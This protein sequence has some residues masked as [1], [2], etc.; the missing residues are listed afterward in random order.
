MSKKVQDAKI[1]TKNSRASLAPRVAH[2]REL[3]S[4]V[5]VGWRDGKWRVRVYLGSG[6][7]KQKPLGLADDNL[8]ADGH[9]VL[10][11][12][13]AQRAAAQAASEILADQHAVATGAVV[14]VRAACEALAL[15]RDDR[16]RSWRGRSHTNSTARNI[17]AKHVFP[18]RIA[19]VALHQLTIADLRS[20]LRDLPRD[21]RSS[22]IKR[23]LNDLRAALNAATNPKGERILDAATIKEGLSLDAAKRP[24]NAKDEDAAPIS[25]LS[26]EDIRRIV[27]SAEA[28]G[29]DVHRMLS[30]L[31]A[32]GCRF[33]QVLRCRVRDLNLTSCELTIPNS[34]KG[35]AKA[36][37]EVRALPAFVVALLRPAVEGR[38]GDAPLFTIRRAERDEFAQWSR[39]GEPAPWDAYDLRSPWRAACIAA[40]VDPDVHT[41]NAL[42]HTSI[43]RQILDRVPTMVVAKRHNT[44][45]QMLESVYAKEIAK[46]ADARETAFEI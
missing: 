35:K 8:P 29:A 39:T 32:T 14:T 28:Q 3:E 5:H 15:V 12:R 42:R 9:G 23:M 30:V 43:Q 11:Y 34:R 36:G 25:F 44:S 20:W 27:K 31:A 4:G 46:A 37:F 17:F 21:L 40:G 6:K 22:S 7:Y 13:Q 33:A 41:P 26:S 2:W 1:T 16:T 19:D 24:V 10:D 45:V 18:H 38:V